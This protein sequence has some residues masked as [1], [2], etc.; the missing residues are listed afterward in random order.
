MRRRS[1]LKM[2]GFG[3]VASSLGS[4]VYRASGWWNQPSSEHTEI[5]STE[6]CEITSAIADAMFPGEDHLEGGMPNG[7]E[8][9]VVE[10]L[11]GYLEAIDARS[12]RLMRL[13]L[14]LIDEMARPRG[15]RLR[16]FCERPRDERI[17]ILKAW[18][19]SSVML[20]R[21]AFRSLKLIF[22]GSYCAHPEVLEAAG[23]EFRCGGLG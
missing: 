3:A 6:E 5:L 16:R 17:A 19:H 7:A 10:H 8:V 15:L 12:S 4:M 13:L 9:G 22:A 11:D 23:I 2:A 1:F 18:D 21:Q 20:R 14:H